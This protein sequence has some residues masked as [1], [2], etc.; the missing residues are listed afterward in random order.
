MMGKRHI[1]G[2]GVSGLTAAWL[3]C[4][5]GIRTEVHEAAPQ[6]GGRCRT[7]MR[8]GLAHDNGTHVLLTANRRTLGLLEAIGAAGRWVEPE[9][10]GLPVVDLASDSAATVGLSPWSWMIRS[11]RPP[12][13]S[14]A[15]LL[16]LLPM[17]VAP[18]GRTVASYAG[19]SSGLLSFLEMTSAAVLNTPPE[20]AS[21]SLLAFVF[22]RLLLPGS[23]RLLVAREGLSPDLIH[24]LAAA[25][26]AHGGTIRFG[27]RLQHIRHDGERVSA[28]KFGDGTV[29]LGPEDEVV[30]SVP[31]SALGH[32]MPEVAVPSAFEPIVNLHWAH[33]GHGPVR[34]IGAT[35]GLAQWILVRPG[36]VSV[37]VSAADGFL[38]RPASE[39]VGS[40]WPEVAMACTRA[41]AELAR[42]HPDSGWVVKER[43]ATPR[44]DA[45]YASLLPVPQRPLANLALAGDWTSGLPAT[46]EGA[47]AAAHAAV[48]ALNRAYRGELQGR[49][50]R[51]T[52]A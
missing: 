39:L 40:V 29:E 4:R 6:A 5:A 30:M 28:L 24:P 45:A 32:L 18:G 34:F 23:A 10:D 26:E 13:V 3:S 7:V 17:M 21:A 51:E 8:Q 20:H 11:R 52:V 2:G 31:P 36:T 44:Q 16:R 37:T 22:R 47:V 19:R 41:G 9:P 33:Q 15:D 14:T 43:V 27:R 35:G 38:D 42:V 12:G 48:Q 25:V 49:T 50:S 1:I 46:I